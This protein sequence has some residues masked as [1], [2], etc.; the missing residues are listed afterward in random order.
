MPVSGDPIFVLAAQQAASLLRRVR[1]EGVRIYGESFEELVAQA[2]GRLIV[3][4]KA[5][6]EVAPLELAEDFEVM[7][8]MPV[9]FY[10]VPRHG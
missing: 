9:A 7:Y 2:K 4:V 6:T 8:G 5:D 1:T 10:A 3:A